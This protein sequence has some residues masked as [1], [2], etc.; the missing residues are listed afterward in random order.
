MK[1]RFSELVV[2]LILLSATQMM[3]Q[4]YQGVLQ[5][6]VTDQSGGAVPGATVTL[7][8]VNTNVRTVLKT[9]SVGLYRFNFLIPD[10]YTVTVESPGFTKFVHENIVVMASSNITVNATLKPGTVRQVVTV[11]G[12]PPLLQT[13]TT[14]QTIT[15][16]STISQNTPRY[17]QNPFKLTLLAPEAINTRGE[18]E[19]YLSWSANSVDLGGGTNLK[20]NLTVDGADVDVGHKYTY[21]PNMGDVQ[22]T[23][24]E[25][26]GVDAQ[27]GHSAGGTINI[28]TKSGTNQFHGAVD[29]LGRYPWLNALYNRTTSPPST[30]ST[31]QNT[32]GVNIGNPIIKNK[33]F[34]FTS[35]NYWKYNSPGSYIVTVPTAAERNGDFSQQKNITGT[36]A[37][38]YNPFSSVYNPATG[39][40]TRTPFPGNIIPQ[41]MMDPVAKQLM[42]KFWNPNGSG[43]NV[44]N[45]DNFQVN[46]PTPYGYWN[47]S[48]R[49]DYDITSKWKVFGRVSGYH[50]STLPPNPTPN[51]S[52]LY[53]PAG[54]L[55]TAHQEMG[56]AVWTLN[57]T[58]IMDFHVSF[59][60]LVDAYVSP[61]TPNLWSTI[62][63]SNPWYQPYSNALPGD[64][65]F[66]YLPSL[67]IGGTGFGGSG[68][69]WDQEPKGE[70]A[71]A[72]YSHM[73]GSHY[74]KAGLEWRRTGGFEYI[75]DSP[76]FYFPSTLTANTSI[77]PNTLL[78]GNGFASFLLGALDNTSET[79][80]GPNSVSYDQYW[81]MYIQDDWKVTRRLTLNLGLRDEYET[82]WYGP[83]M[84]RGL[85]LNASVPQMVANPPIL[86]TAATSLEPNGYYGG[87]TKGL[88]QF[89]GPG[90]GMWNPPKLALAPRVGFAFM[91]DP[92]SVLR[93]GYARYVIPSEY[94]FTAAP[95]SGFEDVNF[96]EPPYFGETGY[97]Y[98]APLLEGV[99]QQTLSN[100]YPAS[101][102]PLVPILGTAYGTNVGRGGENLLW[103]P[104]NFQKAYNDRLDIN[105]QRQLPWGIMAG[106]VWF[107][108]FGNQ[109]YTKELNGI[110]PALEQKYQTSLDV[111]ANNPFYHYLNT[112]LMPGPLYSQPTVPLSSLLVPYP[113]YGPLFEIGACCNG[114]FFSQPQI[115]VLKQFNNGLTFTFGYDHV[116]ERTQINN[117]NDQTYYNNQFQWQNNAQPANHMDLAAVWHLPI[118]QGQPFLHS[119][120][121]A[122]DA[123]VGGW[124][125]S[126][127][128]QYISGDYLQFAGMNVASGN[129]CTSNAANHWFNTSLFSPYPANTYVLRSNPMQYD[130]LTGPSFWDLDAS[131]M[132]NF[133]LSERFNA[134]LRITA[135]NATNRLNLGD[136][137]TTVTDSTFG[138]ALFQGSPSATEGAQGYSEYTTGRQ[139]ELGFKLTW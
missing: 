29:W 16:N 50:T 125:V 36:V 89:D 19:P 107:V 70:S 54:T 3:A 20:N 83:G 86:P 128:L 92:K 97:Q 61:K 71:S 9:S 2:V 64:P 77:S 55:R 66:E 117:F 139:V 18:V 93:F 12:A 35:L 73:M 52:E 47:Y 7:L 136:P 33:L 8:N 27:Y 31:R 132:K 127:V 113:Q 45:A 37:T 69:Y 62:W 59:Q 103:Y 96:V 21:P 39:Q 119:S 1:R 46:F 85:N 104:D 68:L 53:V 51:N 79:I 30:L 102:N 112:T 118:G 28:T 14:N 44:T 91:I 56:D 131:L 38:I 122:V 106:F 24:V 110:N 49:V 15:L 57:P 99:P 94:N 43:V 134:Q 4:V 74:L 121:R 26:T 101:I 5:G 23:T 76:T 65:A 100:P 114:E 80:A 81:G 22:E 129:V 120:S 10:T 135:Y 13:N 82:A 138:E 34:M 108:N 109:L 40:I 90:Q 95:F 78:Y 11:T 123:L 25:Q 67:N 98:T 124:E 87:L 84:S 42:T 115:Q 48:E 63:P 17:D 32:L 105:I 130:C 137:D 133:R 72:D 60:S 75:E 41:S 58:S 126:P 88:W 111:T 116:F 6:L